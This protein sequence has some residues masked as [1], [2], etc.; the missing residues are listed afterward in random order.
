[1][2]C[3]AVVHLISGLEHEHYEIREPNELSKALKTSED[4]QGMGRAS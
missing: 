2:T 4:R 3:E 1:M